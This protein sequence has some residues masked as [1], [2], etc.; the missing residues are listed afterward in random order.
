M[1]VR[2]NW[3]VL[4]CFAVLAML[5]LVFS[6]SGAKAN[7]LVPADSDR[8]HD[9]YRK[10]IAIGKD[11]SDS[12]EPLLHSIPAEEGQAAVR[13][14]TLV[15][16]TGLMASTS[17]ARTTIQALE[18]F[19]MISLAANEKRDEA[20][21]NKVTVSWIGLTLAALKKSRDTANSASGVCEESALV[22]TKAQII[23]NL[24]DQASSVIR[25]IGRRLGAN[26]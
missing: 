22:V 18:G 4:R 16:M 2:R 1:R 24:V 15:C 11:V 19:T 13:L 8:L 6:W 14:K 5:A 12:M 25:P 10:F 21:V 3:I 20:F 9:I 23:L 17:E 7:V 26:E